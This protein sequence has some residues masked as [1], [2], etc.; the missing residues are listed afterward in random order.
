MTSRRELFTLADLQKKTVLPRDGEFVIFTGNNF[1]LSKRPNLDRFN[2]LQDIDTSNIIIAG[3]CLTQALQKKNRTTIQRFSIYLHGVDITKTTDLIKLIMQSLTSK[4]SSLTQFTLEK[5]RNVISLKIDECEYH[6]HT[7]LFEDIDEILDSL[8]F[9]PYQCYYDIARKA[10]FMTAECKKALET[11]RIMFDGPKRF[12]HDTYNQRSIRSNS[13]VSYLLKREFQLCFSELNVEYFRECDEYDHKFPGFRVNFE[14]TDSNFSIYIIRGYDQAEDKFISIDTIFEDVVVTESIARFDEAFNAVLTKPIIKPFESFAIKYETTNM[15]KN[16]AKLLYGMEEW[17]W[18][19]FQT[20]AIMLNIPYYK[21]FAGL[22][23]TKI[24]EMK[25]VYDSLVSRITE[26]D[27]IVWGIKPDEEHIKLV[28]MTNEEW[29]GDYWIHRHGSSSSSSPSSSS[30]SS[31][32]S[33]SSSSSES[34]SSSSSE[35]SSS[36]SSESEDPLEPS[37]QLE[38]LEQS[39]Q[40]DLGDPPALLLEPADS[41]FVLL[42][43]SVIHDPN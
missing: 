11:A 30:S 27:N 15:N 10:L 5:K 40:S 12:G 2:I 3:S 19:C 16:K 13:Y 4:C 20:Q 39:E 17:E 31:S 35:S 42:T 7:V 8:T 43:E 18:I 28:N 23:E 38:Q 37:E 14:L 25:I 22:K 41:S 21:A 34:S 24:A 6:I 26:H 9:Q 33:S 1:E 32:E 29:Y 36:S